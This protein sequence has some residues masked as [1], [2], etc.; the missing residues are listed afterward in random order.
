M[1]DTAPPN[2]SS[3]ALE[4]AK[5]NYTGTFV[6]IEKSLPVGPGNGDGSA[7]SAVYEL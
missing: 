2:Q 7:K 6:V 3:S 1:A 5:G 4:A